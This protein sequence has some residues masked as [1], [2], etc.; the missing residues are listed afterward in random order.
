MY[1]YKRLKTYLGILCHLQTPEKVRPARNAT[2]LVFV[3][4]SCPSLRP[5]SAC[6][7]QASP[8]IPSCHGD[9]I[10]LASLLY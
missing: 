10:G 9:Y 7:S 6:R 4:S 8:P 3:G 2:A 5:S 1:A